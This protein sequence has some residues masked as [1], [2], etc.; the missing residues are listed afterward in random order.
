MAMDH[1][2]RRS[3]APGRD[4]AGRQHLH[5]YANLI[6]MKRYLILA[7]IVGALLVVL[8]PRRSASIPTQDISEPGPA[9]GRNCD[10]HRQRGRD[11]LGTR[12]SLRRRGL[13][14]S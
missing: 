12:E 6:N 11:E 9:A 8:W 10:L 5:R 3:V 7:V 13:A 1:R 2:G 14:R 4:R